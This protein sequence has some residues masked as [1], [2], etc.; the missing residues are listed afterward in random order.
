MET[1]LKILEARKGIT[2]QRMDDLL[3]AESSKELYNNRVVQPFE[4]H[5]A[6]LH[7]RDVYTEDSGLEIRVT[8]KT[9]AKHLS[10]KQTVHAFRHFLSNSLN[11]QAQGKQMYGVKDFDG[12][13]AID[14]GYALEQ[15]E[16]WRSAVTGTQEVVSVSYKT[17]K[18]SKAAGQEIGNT[19][20]GRVVTVGYEP[21]VFDGEISQ[22][23]ASLYV[24]AVVQVERLEE[25]AKEIKGELKALA[26]KDPDKTTFT[27]VLV[28]DMAV[29]IKTVPREEPDYVGAIDAT[30]EALESYQALGASH[31][32]NETTF[33]NQGL[34]EPRAYVAVDALLNTMKGVLANT[35]IKYSQSLSVT[36]ARQPAV[37]LQLD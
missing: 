11:N 21:P 19:H 14:A 6:S 2:Q 25:V 5:A 3:D 22:E 20:A 30:I 24:A 4:A 36:K 1:V 35:E 23:D 26:D 18:A 31:V 10:P 28:G 37:V 8:E 17:T 32:D 27:P 9:R 33:F 15:L 7:V 12:T 29:T 16:A 34:A 13:V